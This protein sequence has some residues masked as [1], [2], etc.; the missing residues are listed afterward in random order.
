MGNFTTKLIYFF[1]MPIYTSALTVEEFGLADLL[2]NSLFLI[3]PILTLSIADA[4]FRFLLDKDSQPATLLNEG[5]KILAYSYIVALF[6][7]ICIYPFSSEIYWGLFFVL[8]V[9]ESLKNLFAQFTRG[10]GKVKTFAING[11]L[12]SFFLL[13]STYILL[14]ILHWGI[15]G[16]LLS[17]IIG[18]IVSIL[19][20]LWR[21]N[22]LSYIKLSSRNKELLKSMLVYSLPLIPNSLS[23]WMT[24]ISSR[25]II[26]GYCGLGI[27]GLFSGASK[28]P[29]LI[30]VVASIFQQS[31]QYAS[32]KEYQESTESIFYSRVFHYYSFFIIV[33]GS[34]T[35][36]ILPYISRLVLLGE[37]YEAWI[38]TPLLVFS[39][40]LGC[41]SIFFGVVY[42]IIKKNRKVLYTT[43]TGALVNLLLCLIL[44][45]FAGVAGAL[46]SNVISYLIIV[47]A[48]IRDT[49]KYIHIS[50]EW[51]RLTVGGTLVLIQATV[52][53]VSFDYRT[54]VSAAIVLLLTALFRR[55]FIGIYHFL[56]SMV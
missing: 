5:L 1:L 32:V 48:R 15:T 14:K 17:F 47:A 50:I 26:A 41:F 19:Y 16:Y 11:V 31:W 29:A 55:D 40:M 21:I 3:I 10:L 56:K 20:L 18:N 33:F 54:I 27:A 34:V 6:V 53:S 38:Y 4:V 28:I 25:Y 9:T 24:N 30:N 13:L 46:I 49:Q 51:L 8:Y 45:P 35:I 52:M 12:G 7:L 44:I 22:I 37:F 39:A 36:F 42:T 23:W 43:L 2:N